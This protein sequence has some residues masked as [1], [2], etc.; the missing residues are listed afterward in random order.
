MITRTYKAS[1]QAKA[2]QKMAAEGAP[3][4]HILGGQSWAQGGRSC[5]AQG[6]VVAGVLLLVIGLVF[7][8]LWALAV[9]CLVIGLVSGRADGELTVT[10][11]PAPEPT[12][13]TEPPT[14]PS[15]AQDP[16]AA[17]TSLRAM[18]DAGLITQEEF[19]AKKAELLAKM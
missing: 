3:P 14:T 16:A 11:L 4:G 1:T 9:I 7:P 17:L 15:T 19:E 10:W 13:G 12:P 6:F 8:P 2:A 18:L 5:A